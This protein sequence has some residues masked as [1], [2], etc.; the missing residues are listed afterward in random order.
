MSTLGERIRLAR[1]NLSQETFS[2]ALNISKGS[3]GFYERNENLPNTEVVLKIC[4][5]TGVSLEWLL[6]GSGPMRPE[7]SELS[8]EESFFNDNESSPACSFCDRLEKRL[9]LL[10]EERRELSAENRR[11]WKENAELRER[12]AR[13]EEREK[14]SSLLPIFDSSQAG[15]SSEHTDHR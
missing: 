13:L 11:L 1:G 9:D 4:S 8:E 3:L 7:D 6:T 5:K 15:R 10:S 14:Q 12:C 2:R